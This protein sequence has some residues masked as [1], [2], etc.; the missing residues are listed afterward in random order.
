MNALKENY[1]VTED[2]EGKGCIGIHLRWDYENKKVHLLML[3]Y[4]QEGLQQFNHEPPKRRQE[5]PYIRATPTWGATVQYRETP[6]E[7][8]RIDAKGKK[9]VQQG[10]G[11]LLFLRRVIDS[12]LLTP[13][14]AIAS[15]QASPTEETM[16]HTKHILNYI[17]SQEDAVLTYSAIK[18]MLAVHNDAG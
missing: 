18:M 6:K 8:P 4:A 14:S 2:W 5:S 7:S 10:T 15:Q 11:K 13:L 1:T 9:F 12:T 3:G 16:A 17:S